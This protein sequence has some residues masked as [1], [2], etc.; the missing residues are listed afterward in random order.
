[1][2]WLSQN[3]VWPLLAIGAFL[4]MTRSGKAGHGGCCGASAP[5][6]DDKRREGVGEER[7]N[8]Q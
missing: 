4:L 1:M 5:H 7:K 3:W 2:E 6:A 8:A